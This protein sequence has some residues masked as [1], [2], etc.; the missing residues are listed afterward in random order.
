MGDM[1]W[2]AHAGINIFPIIM[3]VKLN[4]PLVIWGEIGWDVS[5]MFS[6][7]DFSEYSK[8][9]VFEHDLRGFNW[10]D[11]VGEEGLIEKDFNWMK[12]PSDEDLSK[13]GVRGSY[14]GNYIKWDP[15]IQTEKMIEDY[16]FET[17]RQPFERTYRV[18]S[19]L[20][21]MHENGIHDYMKYIKFGYGRASDHSS[22]DIRAGYM[23][24]PEGIEMVRK[25]DHVKPYNDLK[26]WLEYV[27][28]TEQEFDGIADNFRDPRGWTKNYRGD[29]VKDNIWDN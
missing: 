9:T 18:M 20:D 25:Y 6:P 8:R 13:V 26:R 12:M 24:R 14:I 22:K 10:Q 19:N 3:A 7:N 15:N 5:G 1:N 21:D 28:M 29:W 2:H 11:M 17:A 4:I 23:T 27:G 16:S